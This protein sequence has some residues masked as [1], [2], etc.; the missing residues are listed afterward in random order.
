MKLT[1]ATIAV[2]FCTAISVVAQPANDNFADRIALTGYT[3]VVP[4]SSTTATAEPG[5]PNGKNLL[6]YGSVW[7]EWTAPETGTV[8][9]YY[10][11]DGYFRQF[12]VYTGSKLTSL[13]RIGQ[14]N[15]GVTFEAKEGQVFEIQAM[16]PHTTP[17]YFM[18]LELVTRPAND[19]FTDR[20]QLEGAMVSTNGDSEAATREPGEPK[21]NGLKFGRSL[22]YAW[23]APAS[24]FL[25]VDVTNSPQQMCA[26]YTGSSVSHLK[27][28]AGLLINQSPFSGVMPVQAGTEYE[29]A[30]DG[31]LYYDKVVHSGP[32]TLNLEFTGLLLSSPL[33]NAE[34]SG[35]SQI[36]L[37]AA[38]T[39]PQ[40][41]GTIDQVTF[42]AY[43][44]IS[45]QEIALG[46][47][48]GLAFSLAWMN[49]PN[50]Y[51]RVQARGTN[52]SARVVR[53]NPAIIANRP[54][55][56]DIANSIALE[57][58]NAAWTA[59]FAAATRVKSDPKVA[60]TLQDDFDGS[61][62]WYTWTAPADGTVTISCSNWTIGMAVYTGK[63][64]GFK[65][66]MTPTYDYNNSPGQ[67]QASAG[68]TYQILLSDRYPA[69]APSH[70][71]L[72][73]TRQP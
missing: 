66:V 20:F 33:N 13:H 59:D 49:P 61:T 32:F 12:G 53:S 50:G 14:I 62:L 58:D 71:D 24:G 31:T 15:T 26:P 17:D 28:V 73:L 42:Y 65:T 8:H 51:F 70:G 27:P 39:V 29:L 21:H 72:T 30:V 5:E 1:T 2:L 69:Y 37:N 56:D 46:E 52:D 68:Q 38:D 16:A 10:S 25:F 63:P 54:I 44:V 55:N 48:S 22:W 47:S 64:G 34:F 9:L 3:N 36:Q 43:D 41:D 7:F 40:I 4:I 18:N 57:G 67:F 6:L 19:D 45:G 23:T 11:G 60:K 35:A